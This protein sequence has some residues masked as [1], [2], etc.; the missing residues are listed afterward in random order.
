M[1]SRA[2]VVMVLLSASAAAAPLVGPAVGNGDALLAE[3]TRL[4][5]QKDYP[6]ASEA[7]LKASRANPRLLSAYLQLARSWLAERKLPQACYAYRAFLRGEPEATDREKAQGELQLCERQLDADEAARKGKDFGAA[8]ADPKS[9]FFSA[10]DKGDLNAAADALGVLV[11]GGYLGVDLAELAAKLGGA[12]SSAAD[13]A[14][15]AGL[16]GELRDPAPVRTGLR[17]LEIASDAG[18]PPASS[19]AKAAFLTGL[20][21]LLEGRPKEAEAAFARA[22]KGEGA[23]PS[24]VLWRARAL[25]Q[26]DRNKAVQLLAAE[27]PRDPRTGAAR[28]AASLSASNAQ[29]AAD[30]E[31][32]LFEQRFPP[33]R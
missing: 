33:G 29:A 10:L 16:R 18:S 6:A 13:V 9:R 22:G 27:L 25:A 1:R 11:G 2:L 31:K 8:F 20:A 32:L 5:N 15:R 14:Y 3:G 4:Y 19:E 23:D 21:A 28:V 17:A 26:V 7:F 12:A 24:P 30:L